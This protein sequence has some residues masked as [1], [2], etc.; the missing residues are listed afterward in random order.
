[1]RMMASSIFLGVG[2][3]WLAWRL[4]VPAILLLLTLGC[5]A[6]SVSGFINPDRMFGNLLQPLVSLAVGLIL[7]DLPTQ[8]SN[9][10]VSGNSLTSPAVRGSALCS[11]VAAC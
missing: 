8:S 11:D 3:Q 5:L 2:G 4:R 7:F 1:M 10:S 9:T 6:G